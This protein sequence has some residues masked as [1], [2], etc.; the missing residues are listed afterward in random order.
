[1]PFVLY[2]MFSIS[3]FYHADAYPHLLLFHYHHVFSAGPTNYNR[4][5][6]MLGWLSCD[7][8]VWPIM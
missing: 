6:F 7:I 1:M 3:G 2:V 5:I 8:E 4:D